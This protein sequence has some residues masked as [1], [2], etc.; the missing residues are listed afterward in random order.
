MF[1]I[2]LKD[3][4]R[5]NAIVYKTCVTAFLF[6][7]VFELIDLTSRVERH[8]L[9]I[10]TLIL[11][12]MLSLLLGYFNKHQT[13]ST[14]SP[15]LAL[16]NLS[17]V[18]A[19][20]IYSDGSLRGLFIFYLTLMITAIF[21]NTRFLIYMF[22]VG[23]GGH[24]YY[25]IHSGST[26]S[27]L[28]LRM[29]D[30]GA[31]FIAA[32]I[33]VYFSQKITNFYLVDLKL[34]HMKTIELNESLL[35]QSLELELNNKQLLRLNQVKD[36]MIS[37]VSH[38]LR[39]PIHAVT[40]MVSSLLDGVA[41]PLSQILQKNLSVIQAS[42]QRLT[43]L[44]NDILDF[45]KLSTND[46]EFHP[47][48]IDVKLILKN[49]LDQL[50]P[51]IGMKELVIKNELDSNFVPRVY[52]DELRV[53]QIFRHLISNAI[54]FSDHG[55]I[56]VRASI[57]EQFVEFVIK[58]SGIGIASDR[59]DQIFNSFEQVDGSLT[60]RYGGTG[61]GLSV[62]KK[63]VE[64]HGGE[65]RV[66]SVLGV[67]SEFTF[68]L[69]ISN[70]EDRSVSEVSMITS[71]EK[72]RQDLNVFD[73]S[74]ERDIVGFGEDG[75]ILVVDDEP[76]N[77]HVMS[78]LLEKNYA[79]ITVCHSGTEALALLK[80]GMRPDL[81]LLDVM[82]PRLSG[83]ETLQLLRKTYSLEQMPV[84]LVTA[85]NSSEDKQQGFTSGANDY[86][87]KPFDR[88]ELL[89]RIHAHLKLQR[90]NYKLT[91]MRNR[92]VDLLKEKN[93]QVPSE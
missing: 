76:I 4:I 88:M 17:I 68:T 7:I 15:Y 87:V 48:S 41:G 55:K 63:L 29:V 89:S 2:N 77:L 42:A 66:R 40:G 32:G 81:V 83:Y 36:H 12:L 51:N 35:A 44:V 79:K 9:M 67:G 16:F 28:P 75:H 24:I 30:T 45:S 65:I 56:S 93:I 13:R 72:E 43:A 37:N 54:K 10:S 14:W 82:M 62:A 49:T 50:E 34:A 38:E 27:E 6:G 70:Q 71:R 53:E 18:G 5:K 39:T 3:Q 85:K 58:D 84:I 26:I 20:F 8:Y 59:F 69:P 60:R 19:L 31:Y 91:V 64:L 52:A 11:G 80:S 61:L 73:G 92:L 74:S 33:I 22:T 86:I 57:R 78:V 46:L 23:L 21:M 25:F 1:D 90:A 47:K